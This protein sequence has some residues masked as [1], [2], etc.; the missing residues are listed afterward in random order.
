M[1]RFQE[2]LAEARSLDRTEREAFM[3]HLLDSLEW[4][5]PAPADDDAWEDVIAERSALNDDDLE[6]WESVRARFL[7]SPRPARKTW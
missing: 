5:T 4:P 2:L 3:H 1:T 6:D 7:A